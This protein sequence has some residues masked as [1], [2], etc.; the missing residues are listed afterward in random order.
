MTTLY[1]ARATSTGTGR[2]G[3]VESDDGVL[4]QDLSI[5]AS[6]GGAGGTGTN[7]EQL[8]A[9]G[10]SACFHSAMLGVGRRDKLDLAGSSVTAQVSLDRT[11]DAYGIA[12]VLEIAA[13]ALDRGVTEQLAADA[14]KAC[15][16]SR[17]TNGNIDVE[18]RVV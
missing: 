14:H 15:P 8:F 12:V 5:P 7:P 1:T 4:V 10:Y 6:M 13:P 17:A 9:A 2:G 18:L 11:D 16:Y 3:H